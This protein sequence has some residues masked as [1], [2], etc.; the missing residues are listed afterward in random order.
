MNLPNLLTAARIA[1][2]PVFVY[3]L[4]DGRNGW[5]LLV[6]LLAAITDGLDG[7]IARVYHLQTPL[8]AILDPAADKLLLVTAYL[9]LAA[10]G[11]VP[12]W[13]TTGIVAR[14][15]VLLLGVGLFYRLA[16]HLEFSPSLAGKATTAMQLITI[17]A[18]LLSNFVGPV[19][20]LLRP[21][22]ALTLAVTV[23]SGVCYLNAG[24]RMLSSPAALKR[25]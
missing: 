6:F 5:A 7:Y 13:L 22:Y 11:R 8:G 16:G 1:L 18:I 21:L 2:V 23:L 3:L 15:L 12:L 10:L 9:L 14:D 17:V 25:G 19:A 24:V 20:V 4:L